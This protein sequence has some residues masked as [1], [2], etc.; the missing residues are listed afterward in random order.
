[1]KTGNPYFRKLKMKRSQQAGSLKHIAYSVLMIFTLLWLTVSTPFVYQADQV[2]KKL[3]RQSNQQSQAGNLFSN[4]TEEQNENS[5]NTLS[6]YLH[7]T[8]L[9]NSHFVTVTR[10]YNHYPSIIVPQHHPELLSPP[11]EA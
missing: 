6:E 5:V 10:L 2:Q 4:I 3:S 7:E 8:Q 9:V 1:M 11:P